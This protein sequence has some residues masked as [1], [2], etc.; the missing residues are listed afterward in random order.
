MLTVG[1]E[2]LIHVGNQLVSSRLSAVVCFF[3]T[4]YMLHTSSADAQGIGVYTSLRF[5]RGL[6]SP[7]VAT[8][9]EMN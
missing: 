9:F 4:V 6:R 7:F 1:D 8:E 2:L 5:R 3:S